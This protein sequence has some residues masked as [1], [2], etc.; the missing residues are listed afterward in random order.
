MHQGERF[1]IVVAHAQDLLEGPAEEQSGFLDLLER[2]VQVGR[3]GVVYS[4]LLNLFYKFF[5]KRCG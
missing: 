4:E 3:V 5:D 2:L 1:G